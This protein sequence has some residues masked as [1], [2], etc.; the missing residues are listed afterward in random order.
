MKS[1]VVWGTG[2]PEGRDSG[3]PTLRPPSRDREDLHT[4]K[5]VRK[6]LIVSKTNGQTYGKFSLICSVSYSLKNNGQF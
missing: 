3:Q 6:I 4:E 2:S 1:G 5:V